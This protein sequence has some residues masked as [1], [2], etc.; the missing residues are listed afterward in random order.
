MTHLQTY[1]HAAY[2]AY[3]EAANWKTH[4]GR[5]MPQWYALPERTQ[6]LWAVAAARV[7]KEFVEVVNN[8]A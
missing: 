8:G 1:A 7:V 5:L 6:K 2:E 4:D 3:G